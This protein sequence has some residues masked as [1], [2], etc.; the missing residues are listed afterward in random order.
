VTRSYFHKSVM[1]VC[2]LTQKWEFLSAV[3]KSSNAET[4]VYCSPWPFLAKP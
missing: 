2:F 4:A 1:S 3:P